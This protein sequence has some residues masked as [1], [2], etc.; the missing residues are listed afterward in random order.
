MDALKESGS[1]P[2]RFVLAVS[3]SFGLVFPATVAVGGRGHDLLSLSTGAA[4]TLALA[5][6]ASATTAVLVR[7]SR[8]ALVL[9]AQGFTVLAVGILNF[10]VF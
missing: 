9:I 3:S 2:T 7:R 10:V 1:Y 8:I 4:V 6:L 5:V